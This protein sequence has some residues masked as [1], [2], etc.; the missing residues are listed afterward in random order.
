M[1][2]PVVGAWIV[3]AF[4][5]W[6]TLRFESSRQVRV[7]MI[8]SPG[9]AMGLAHELES[10]KIRGYTVV[11]WLADDRTTVESG[12]GSRFL[13]SLGSRFAK[14]SS[15]TRSNSSST[16]ARPPGRRRTTSLSSGALRAGRLELPRPP[17]AS[18]R[19]E[20]TLR[21][22]PRSRPSRQV[23]LGLVSVPA[24]SSLPSGLACIEAN[25]RPSGRQHDAD[26]YGAGAGGVRSRRQADRR[27]PRV[28]PT[29]ASG[30]ER[31]RVRD[32]QAA[33]DAGYL[34][35]GWPHGGR[36]RRTSG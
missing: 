13:G 4:A 26:S 33:L 2:V 30:G 35:G 10:A 36:R 29:A 8:G 24:S 11:G 15:G 16:R 34:R 28:L 1:V 32:D 25:F 23:E 20:S 27:R 6:I 17:C 14:W 9:L 5:A 3:T 22:S 19:G 7:A 12:R 21:G 31:P 18:D